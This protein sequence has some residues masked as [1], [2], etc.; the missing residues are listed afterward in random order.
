MLRFRVS[1]RDSS[2]GFRSRVFHKGFS[3]FYKLVKRVFVQVYVG[4]GFGVLD[5]GVGE[6]SI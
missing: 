3:G 1:L 6:L 2:L 5:V 4:F